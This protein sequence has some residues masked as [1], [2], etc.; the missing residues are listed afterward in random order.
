MKNNGLNVFWSNKI[1]DLLF[2][3]GVKHACISPGSR[4]TPLINAFI[5]Y[6]K[7]KC[8]SHFDE[9]SNAFFA[10][11]IAKKS[12]DPVV[13]L[14]TSGTATA[15]LFP[16]IIEG[17]LTMVPLIILTADRP[18]NL[19]DSGENQ[20]I[21]QINLYGDYVR[22]MEN[23]NKNKS[24]TMLKKIDSVVNTSLGLNGIPGPIHLNIRF[25]EPLIDSNKM[26]ISYK[27]KAIKKI[28][29]KISLSI[30]KFK[31]PIIVCG[32][33]SNSK[34]AEIIKLSTKLNC[35]ILADS[36]SNLRHYKN[37]NILV[38]YDHYINKLDKYPDCII[39]FGKKPISKKLTAFINKLK[40]STYLIDSHL[41]FND[42]CPNIIFS[43]L[44][45]VNITFN[46]DIDLDWTKKIIDYEHKT[47]NEID[48][49]DFNNKSEISLINIIKNKLNNNDHL[50]IGNSMPIR[51]FDQFSGKLNTSLKI[52]SNRGA[53]GID[54]IVSTAL[55]V[56]YLNKKTKNFLLIGDVSLF[57]DTNA[58]HILNNENINLTIII[59]NNNGGQIF[60]RLPYSNNDIKEFE[61]FWIT[62]P[63]TQINDLA[64]LF[65]L[66]YYHLDIKEI[67]KKL[68][69][70]SIKSGIKLIEV[71]INSKTDIKII[72]KL[73]QK[74]N[75]I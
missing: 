8:F 23:F 37:K 48:K 39:R 36:L 54:G 25:D 66:K 43:T 30:K 7:I 29:K 55:G 2:K 12:L 58:F 42:D 65:K 47:K 45:N 13:I 4:N 67:D 9:R 73:N 33:L 21:N 51:I 72:E 26:K 18:G 22:K 16:A 6:P 40:K 49:L 32:G 61:K 44:N 17:S 14:T 1:V 38:Y 35:I 57:H 27:P 70:I 62:P 69:T 75:L 59:V 31:R 41:S 56:S 71:K 63:L 34:E 20:T 5:N 19:I 60:S 24:T 46:K 15:N 64:Q 11:G 74:L 68:N 3:K 10:L 52:F 28:E 50:F 53:S